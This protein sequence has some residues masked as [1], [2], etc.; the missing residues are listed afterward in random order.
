MHQAINNGHCQRRGQRDELLGGPRTL[1]D[2]L[3]HQL[4]GRVLGPVRE[5]GHGRGQLRRRRRADEGHQHVGGVAREQGRLLRQGLL[6]LAAGKLG[7]LLV[8]HVADLVVD[9]LEHG[10]Q[11]RGPAKVEVLQVGL[12]IAGRDAHRPQGQR[13]AWGARLPQ[14]R[15]QRHVDG[16]VDE[17][18]VD[19]QAFVDPEPTAQPHARELE[20]DLWLLGRANVHCLHATYGQARAVAAADVDNRARQCDV[21]QCDDEALQPG[22]QVGGP[23]TARCTRSTIGARDVAKQAARE[24]GVQ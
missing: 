14:R 24:Q 19:V 17:A 11:G 9:R 3:P 13:Q 7:G 10:L 5:R 2:Q 12:H 23:R 6:Q 1:H 4:H 22:I 8:D 21:R 18:E 16:G 15:G 20:A